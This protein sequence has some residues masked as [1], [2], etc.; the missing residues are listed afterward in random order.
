M[1]TDGIRRSMPPRLRGRAQTAHY[2]IR[3]GV[4]KQVAKPADLGRSERIELPTWL[5]V[6][7]F[8]GNPVREPRSSSRPK[9]DSAVCVARQ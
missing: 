2:L 7:E 8:E 6:A 4:V 9:V 5:Q 3:S 1:E